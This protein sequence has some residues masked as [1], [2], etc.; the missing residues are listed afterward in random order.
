MIV[1]DPSLVMLA[2][3]QAHGRARTPAQRRA[4]NRAYNAWA[5]GLNAPASGSVAS[6]AAVACANEYG[7]YGLFVEGLADVAATVAAVGAEDA[8][9]RELTSNEDWFVDQVRDMVA[10]RV[11]DYEKV[12]AWIQSQATIGTPVYNAAISTAQAVRDTV[13]AAQQQALDAARDVADRAAQA[14]EKMTA[15]VTRPAQQ[16]VGTGKV[17]A[18]GLLA[19]AGFWLWSQS[20]PRSKG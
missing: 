8:A 19:L 3:R 5:E 15:D 13:L 18:V 17:V 1:N 9:G 7:I 6:T 14:A 2:F 4:V 12:V 16:A 20:Q 10:A 11:E